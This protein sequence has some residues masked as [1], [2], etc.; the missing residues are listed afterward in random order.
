MFDLPKIVFAKFIII[1]F[2]S[3]TRPVIFYTPSL[4][5]QKILGSEC[6]KNALRKSAVTTQL[7][8]ADDV[9]A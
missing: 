2:N 1:E 5:N 7:K 9:K 8:G 3:F 4:E 6:A